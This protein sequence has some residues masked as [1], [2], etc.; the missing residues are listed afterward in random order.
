M[1]RQYT[2]T[3]EGVVVRVDA[4]GV[5]EKERP[6]WALV[7]RKMPMGRGRLKLMTSSRLK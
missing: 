1:A 4:V 2:I 6:Q 3:F 5:S 7:Q